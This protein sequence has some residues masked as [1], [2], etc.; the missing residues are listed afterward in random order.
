M[1]SD[2]R[3][4]GRT[5]MTEQLV[6]TTR[7]SIYAVKWYELTTSNTSEIEVLARGQLFSRKVENAELEGRHGYNSLKKTIEELAREVDATP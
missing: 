5:W 7:T 1:A 2:G 4:N 3:R 6:T